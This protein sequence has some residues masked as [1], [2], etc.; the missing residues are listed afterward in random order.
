MTPKSFTLPSSSYSYFYS[1]FY[2]PSNVAPLYAA[3]GTSTGLSTPSA[4]PELT[5]LPVLAILVRTVS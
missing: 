2:S 4:L 1:Y 3:A 5:V